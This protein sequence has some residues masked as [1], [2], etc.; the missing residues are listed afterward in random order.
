MIHN[1]GGHFLGDTDAGPGGFV[2]TNEAGV[3]K[4][5]FGQGFQAGVA[6]TSLSCA[7]SANARV[8][9]RDCLCALDFMRVRARVCQPW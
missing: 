7:P 9:P 2:G 1:K 4:D 3:N 8:R 6:H 5:T